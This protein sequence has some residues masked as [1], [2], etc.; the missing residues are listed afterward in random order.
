MRCLLVLRSQQPRVLLGLTLGLRLR[1]Q[2][3][4]L[5]LLGV[6]LAAAGWARQAVRGCEVAGFVGAT[7]GDVENVIDLLGASVA[8]E[9]AAAGVVAQCAGFALRPVG[10]HDSLAAIPGHS[11]APLAKRSSR[12]AAASAVFRG[13]SIWD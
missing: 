9:V 8:T 5:C 11:A 3:L 7:A 2:R 13:F 1:E 12:R 10:R 4:G 6:T